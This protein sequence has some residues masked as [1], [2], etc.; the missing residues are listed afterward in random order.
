MKYFLPL[1]IT[2]T[3]VASAQTKPQ[4]LDITLISVQKMTVG[5]AYECTGID[6]KWLEAHCFAPTKE[7]LAAPKH[8]YLVKATFDKPI[9]ADKDGWALDFT[10]RL[11]SYKSATCRANREAK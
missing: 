1:F 11:D 3:S 10:C 6:M 7:N 4:S 9:E 2:L 5:E 8:K